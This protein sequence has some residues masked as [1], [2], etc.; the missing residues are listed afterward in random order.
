MVCFKLARASPHRANTFFQPKP[1]SWSGLLL[2]TNGQ[3][4]NSRRARAKRRISGYSKYCISKRSKG[5]LCPFSHLAT[6][7]STSSL[8]SQ[9]PFPASDPPPSVLDTIIDEIE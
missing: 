7:L 3:N 6:R 4:L 8:K 5:Q 1:K 2:L 9:L